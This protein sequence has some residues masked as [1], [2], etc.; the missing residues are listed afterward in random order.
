[1]KMVR[2]RYSI[3]L[4]VWLL[5]SV[6]GCGV[7]LLPTTMDEVRSPWDSF[8]EAKTAFDKIMVGETDVQGLKALG[9]DPFVAANI[10]I[11]TYLD[12]MARF[13]PNQAIKKR[14]L[15]RGIR[16]CLESQNDCLAYETT[17]QVFRS[18][19]RGN[20]FLDLFGFKR[21]TNRSGW[22]FQ[23]LVVITEGAVV[24]KLWGG[25]PLVNETTLIK[26][27]LG[28]LQEAGSAAVQAARVIF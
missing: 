16:Q 4:T 15:D 1:M 10:E 9:F 8:D 25:K 18:E 12:I 28:P 7:T 19:R 21:K 13:V 22:Q 20:V 6:S 27:P 11:L 14:D 23:A 17:V 26:K 2:H 3:L 5:F 24:Y